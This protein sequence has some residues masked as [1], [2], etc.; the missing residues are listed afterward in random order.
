M[1]ATAAVVGV[2]SLYLMYDVVPARHRAIWTQFQRVKYNETSE[3]GFYW[4]FP[5]VTG[6]HLFTGLDKDE[7]SYTCGT[8]DGITF[9]GKVAI[10]NQLLPENVLESFLIHGE[11]PDRA[12]IFDLS[13]FLMQSICADMTAREFLVDKF[14]DIDDLLYAAL[15]EAQTKAKSG[16]KIEPGK[17]KVFKPVP[18]NSNIADII[19]KE[20]EHRQ[21]T[22][23]ADEE[24]KLN[25]KQAVL[26]KEK[27]AAE[28]D[29][30]RAR[31]IAEQL[32][33]T[34]SQ[35]TELERQ[36]DKLNAEKERA[37]IRHEMDRAAAKKEADVTN[38]LAEAKKKE[39]IL[40]A[41]A[42]VAYLTP[43]KLQEEAIKSFY[44]N[45]KHTFGNKGELPGIVGLLNMDESNKE[46]SN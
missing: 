34:D 7:V 26:A 33:R 15:V 27:Q 17:V 46:P 22:R 9:K 6:N 31:N 25:A 3:P 30:A 45:H 36:K 14:T 42:N 41:E 29:L 39:K 44:N 24:Q 43:A 19:K 1:I 38:T 11:N 35:K 20:A 23:T 13:E 37:E 12:N 40:E 10:T 18:T 16:L 8:K 4:K 32:R 5:W 28:E 21:S 2:L